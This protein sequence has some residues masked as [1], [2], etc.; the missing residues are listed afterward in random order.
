ML[1]KKIYVGCTEQINQFLSSQ[2]A[3]DSWSVLPGKLTLHGLI[4]ITFSRSFLCKY[5]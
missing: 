4:Q 3:L 5:L 2:V 1:P